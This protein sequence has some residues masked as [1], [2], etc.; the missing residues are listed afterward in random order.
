MRGLRVH[1][2][3]GADGPA[4]FDFST[5]ANACGPQPAA[6]QAVR[7]ADRRHYPDPE[8]RAL[9][10]RLAALHGVGA[11]RVLLAAS[12]SEFIFRCTAVADPGAVRV[13][14]FGFGDYAAAAHAFDKAVVHDVDPRRERRVALA[15]FADPGSPLGQP[16]A[17]PPTLPDDQVL[18]VLDRACAPLRL[19]GRSAWPA[20]AARAVFQLWSPNKALGLTGVRGAYAIAPARSRWTGRLQAACPSWPLGA[21]GAAMLAAWTEPAVQRWVAASRLRLRGWQRS[22]QA[23]L[24]ALGFEPLP[25]VAN[26]FVVRPPARVGMRRVEQALAAEGLRWRDTLS[27]GLPG[28]WR[29]SVQPPRAQQALRACL[30]R[31]LEPCPR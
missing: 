17:A 12:A 8:G 25:S 6:W 27:F 14:R 11:E 4:R 15:W 5:T 7:R 19:Q 10:E 18:Q 2:G 26:F 9:R 22:Q 24:A 29:V 21:D 30:S 20:A 31:A 16:E 1:G 23:L 13:P 28:A 3:P